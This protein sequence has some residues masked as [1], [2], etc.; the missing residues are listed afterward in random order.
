MEMMLGLPEEESHYRASLATFE[1]FLRWLQRR[2][3]VRGAAAL[4]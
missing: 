1:R 4:G 3:R 2:R